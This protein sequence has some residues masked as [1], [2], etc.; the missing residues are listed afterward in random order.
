MSGFV[1]LVSPDSLDCRAA[2]DPDLEPES[3]SGL[4]ADYENRIKPLLDRLPPR[5]ADLIELYY[6]KRKR[7]TDLAAIFNVTQAAISYR[8]DRGIQRIRFLL[9]VPELSDP[10]IRKDLSRLFEPT[11]VNVL[12]GMWQTTCQSEV[13][14]RLGLTQARVRHRFFRSV[15]R[16][17][18]EA[19]KDTRYEPYE[20]VFSAISSRNFNIL[21]AVRLPQWHGRKNTQAHTE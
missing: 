3:T 2:P 15:E 6:G 18:I 1:V 20:R 5:E 11:D 14:S 13:A 19:K 9:S 16:L 4:F 7:Q 21:R 12:V 8:L 17:K 10:K